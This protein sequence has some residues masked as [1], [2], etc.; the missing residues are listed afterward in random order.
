MCRYQ[1]A[2]TKGY[3]ARTRVERASPL[4]KRLKAIAQKA[5]VALVDVDGVRRLYRRARGRNFLRRSSLLEG[6][7]TVQVARCR[8]AGLGESLCQK[9]YSTYGLQEAVSASGPDRVSGPITALAYGNRVAP[10]HRTT[11]K[12]RSSSVGFTKSVCRSG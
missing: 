11:T 12:V 2:R 9:F 7:L 3:V 6:R 8:R 1:D 4:G 5:S 10:P